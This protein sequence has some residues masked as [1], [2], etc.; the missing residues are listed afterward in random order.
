MGTHGWVSGLDQHRAG[1]VVL[2]ASHVSPRQSR[3]F[4]NW[5]KT[6]DFSKVLSNP[7]PD[8]LRPELSAVW[9]TSTPKIKPYRGSP[10]ETSP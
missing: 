2:G 8:T 7:N 6:T 1:A 9:G 3:I 10:A 5:L 4:C